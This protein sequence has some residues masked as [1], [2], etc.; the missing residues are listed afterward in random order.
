MCLTDI[1]RLD[2]DAT[3]DAAELGSIEEDSEPFTDS[4]Q[5]TTP[6]TPSSIRGETQYMSMS[7]N[8]QELGLIDGSEQK[9]YSSSSCVFCGSILGVTQNCEHCQKRTQ[10]FENVAIYYPV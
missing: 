3:E 8:P 10:S 7:C 9:D 4:P 2:P 1:D 6:N 5:R